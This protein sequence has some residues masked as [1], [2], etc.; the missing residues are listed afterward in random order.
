MTETQIQLWAYETNM[1]FAIFVENSH[2]VVRTNQ[3]G[4]YTRMV[5][6]SPY[7]DQYSYDWKCTLSQ[8]VSYH[9]GN[10]L[11]VLPYNLDRS[12]IHLFEVSDIEEEEEEKNGIRIKTASLRD[13]FSKSRPEPKLNPKLLK[14]HFCNLQYYMDEELREHEK[15]W[16]TVVSDQVNCTL[17]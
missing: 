5:D 11:Q 16:H 6:E 7:V 2:Y 9:F 1:E 14:C 8:W 17:P 10:Q 13:T 12:V 15:F 3:Q 4:N